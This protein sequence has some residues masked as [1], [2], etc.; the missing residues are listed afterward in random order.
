MSTIWFLC[1]RS[2]RVGSQKSRRRSPRKATPTS[3]IGHASR[4]LIASEDPR[5]LDYEGAEFVLIGARSDP[6]RAYD[7]DIETEHE[8]ARKADIF[9]PLKMSH[10]S[11]R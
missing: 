1:G 9:R 8:T 3:P 11:T 6:E 2:T 5:L 4:N 7:I 10:A